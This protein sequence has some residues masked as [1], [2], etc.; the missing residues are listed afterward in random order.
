[1][2]WIWEV[3]KRVLPALE[4]AGFSKMKNNGKPDRFW[5]KMSCVWLSV[6]Y[7]WDI[8]VKLS[9]RQLEL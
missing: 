8:L 3:V 4:A 6:M 5:G 2:C 9:R 1:M 7:L